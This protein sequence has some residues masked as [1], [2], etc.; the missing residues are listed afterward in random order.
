MITPEP[1]RGFDEDEYRARTHRIQ[2]G[3]ATQNLDGL[4]LCSE[5]EVRYFSGFHTPFWQSP[6][7]PWF[8]FIPSEGNPVAIIPE[9][10]AALM[11]KTWIIDIRSWNAPSPADDGISLL[12]ELLQPLASKGKC[13]GVM[14][15]HETVLRMP[16]GD[17]ECLLKDL[18]GLEIKD[19]TRLVQAARMVKSNAEIQKLKYICSVGSETFLS[20]PNLIQPNMSLEE[21]IRTFRLEALKQGADDVPYVVGSAAT[22]G[23]ADVISLPSKR[24]IN[25]G[26]ILMIDSGCVWDGYFCDF[27][28]NWAIE[29]SDDQSRRV[30]DV[31]WRATEAGIEAAKS[32]QRACD[33]FLAMSQ[34]LV[35]LNDT[36][37]DI[38]RLGHGLG[39]QLTEQPSVAF[40]D[41]TELKENMVLTLEPSVSYG[42]GLMMVHEENVIVTESGGKLLTQRAPEELPILFSDYIEA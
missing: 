31:L 27:D 29:K 6:T 41:Q 13:L 40:F 26:D 23:Y 3:M 22:G 19:A 20:L 39:M 42:D 12:R 15:G 30:Y 18:N 7:R 36:I 33:L 1:H 2:I 9:I 11:R 21:V 5:A 28:R 8:L 37:G 25:R 38:G 35:E 14:K 10:G 32:G 24:P 16:L 4:L 17:W 34:V